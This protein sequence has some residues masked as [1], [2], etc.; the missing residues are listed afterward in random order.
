MSYGLGAVLTQRQADSCWRLVAYASRAMTETEHMYAQV[1]KEALAVTWACEKFADYIIGKK[2]K[3]KT[4][5]KPL[6]PLLGSMSLASLPP[7]IQRFR[8][9]LM[10][11]TYQIVHVP[12]KDLTTAD[13]LSRAPLPNRLTEDETKKEEE[14]KAY[15]ASVIQELPATADRHN[16]LLR[17][18]QQQDEVIS[19]IVK[20][21]ANG[22]PEKDRLDSVLKLYCTVRG[23]LTVQSGLLMKGNRLVIPSSQYL[24]VLD[25]LHEGHQGITRCRERAKISVWWPG[26]SKQLEEKVW[27]CSI[28]ARERQNPV[29]PAI[30]SQLPDRP[31]QKVAVDRFELKGHLYLQVVDYFSRFL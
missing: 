4:D 28:C 13:T 6:I 7:R 31:W 5:H 1:E 27:R 2:F 15:V 23:E 29:E 10:R 25:R 3:L 30:V 17:V 19:T 16:T 12:G 9:R 18:H 11:M 26:L 22:W 24:D 21:C 20:T 14:V 8:M